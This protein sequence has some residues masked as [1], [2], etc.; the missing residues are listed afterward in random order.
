MEG[1]QA[2]A[3]MVEQDMDIKMSRT[4]VGARKVKAGGVVE[5][6]V[7]NQTLMDLMNGMLGEQTHYPILLV[8][9]KEQ[10]TK[11]LKDE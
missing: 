11:L 3:K 1:M 5:M 2:L 7:D 4:M 6:G 9:N 10:Y 8:V